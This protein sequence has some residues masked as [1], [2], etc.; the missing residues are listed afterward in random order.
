MTGKWVSEFSASQGAFHVET[1]KELIEGNSKR[2]LE[3]DLDI[4]GLYTPIGVFDTV[5]EATDH[6][7][8]MRKE[9]E[10]DQDQIWKF[11][12]RRE[13]WINLTCYTVRRMF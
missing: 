10:R 12:G 1:L 11:S 6:C 9:L 3:G 8:E 4:F 7:A 5:D 2:F 13:R